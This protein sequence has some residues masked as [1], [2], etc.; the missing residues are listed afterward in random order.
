[1]PL[2]ASVPQCERRRERGFT[3]LELMVVVAILG[4]LIALV[5]PAAIRILGNT[6]HKIAAQDI[7]RTSE[8]LEMYKLDVGAYPASEDGLQALI[9]GP[10]GP[11]TGAVPISRATSCRSTPGAAPSS[12]AARR[13]ALV[14]I[15]ICAP[16]VPMA[17]P[18]APATT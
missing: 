9:S 7:A 13:V 10:A 6:K 3:L 12:I 11:I 16:T 14:T 18:V 1:M 15:T 17:S 2:S 5:A 4:L 8:P